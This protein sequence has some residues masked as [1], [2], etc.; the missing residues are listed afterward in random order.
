MRLALHPQVD[1]AIH[2]FEERT[3][4]GFRLSIPAERGEIL[5][6]HME[7]TGPRRDSDLDAIAKI[8][9]MNK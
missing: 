8:L 4:A 9:V 7:N 3:G 5:V 1:S 2:L 6:G